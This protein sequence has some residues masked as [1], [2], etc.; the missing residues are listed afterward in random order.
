MQ[1]TSKAYKTEQKQQL[2]NEQFVYVYLGVISKEAQSNAQISG[3]FTIYSS[4]Q[5]VTTNI[6]FEAYYETAEQNLARCD[7]SQYFMPRNTSLFGLYQGAVTQ[8][9]LSPVTFTFG[10]YER[11]NIKGLT[12]DFGDFYPTNFT[13][14]NGYAAN[15]YTYTNSSPGKWTC[16]DEFLNTSFIKITPHAMV[17]GEQ[18]LRILS[19]L[20]GVGFTF[21]NYN[22]ISTSYKSEVA[23]LSDSLPNK[24]FT[25]TIDNLSRKFSADN[26]H[27][28]IA[29]LQEQQEVEFQYGRRMDDDSIYL[30]PGGKLNLKSW[31]STDTQAKFSAVGNLNYITTSYYKGKYYPNGI[32]LYD[33]AVEV[34]QDAGIENYRIDSYLKKVKTHNP[35]PVE[36]HKNLI[37]LIANAARCVMYE[38][39]TGFITL[40]TSFMPLIT[41][42]SDTG[43]TDYSDI[44]S[45]LEEN[46]G[47]IEYATSEKD[48][49]Y[50][51]GHQYF[52]P[53]D[54][55]ALLSSGFVS[56]TVSNSTG[57]F[58][59][60]SSDFIRFVTDDDVITGI[61]FTGDIETLSGKFKANGIEVNFNEETIS[62]PQITISWEA[63]WTFYNMSL[64]F[65][66]V[67]P[68]EVLI[69][70]YSNGELVNTID[71]T[72][73]SLTT[74]IEAAFN[75]IDSITIAFYKTSPYQRI[76]LGKIIFGD[77]SD[78]V[79]EYSDMSTSPTATRTD[80]IKNVNVVYSEYTYGTEIKNIGTVAVVSEENTVSYKT[81]Y[82]DYSLQY[83]ELTDDET[84]YTKVSKVFCDELPPID[85]AKSSTRYFVRTNPDYE[86]YMLKTENDTKTWQS[87]GIFTETTVDELPETLSSNTL[88]LIP[89]DTDLIY[90]LYMKDE[91]D[92]DSETVS[93]GY[94]VRGTL[95]I[96]DSGAYFVSFTSNVSSPVVVSAIAFLINERTY[97][98]ELHELGQDKTANNV[99]IDNVDHAKD[100]AEWL[101]DYYDNDIEYKISY[102][103]EP[104]L[105]PD[106]QIYLENK[107][108]EKNLVRITSTQIDT[109]TGMSM[110][111]ILNTRRISYEEE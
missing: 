19:I 8:D 109:S 110:S 30:I 17:G 35:L 55:S 107:F 77:I 7:G 111:C 99:L 72:E 47:Y 76:H 88:Y 13:I 85:S 98:N 94:D 45:I 58:D 80:Y 70:C 41:Q 23:H 89:T 29:F 63:T 62:S 52:I 71:Q 40:K 11:L 81:A 2:R 67:C 90:H 69:Y 92:S 64:V 101:A 36:N 51:D 66:D 15:T 14:T 49:S 38:D 82:H 96:T 31:S 84:T 25:F 24:T 5:E 60:I 93:L 37:Q 50:V 57:E 18:K 87:Y 61:E 104:A 100:E 86:M 4:P 97:T 12:I 27:S 9:T 73:I 108:V 28:F 22:L 42:I 68:K 48:F 83:K 33:L 103:G 32:S 105:D 59:G 21:D 74:S 20:F 91:T 39:R 102:R 10:D 54:S 65:S 46:T 95:T 53:R 1:I 34:F 44:E 106:D 75:E 26:P 16:E 3:D 6:P 56:D 43:H 79:L 78:Y